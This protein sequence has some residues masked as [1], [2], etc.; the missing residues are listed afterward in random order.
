MIPGMVLGMVHL[1]AT[2][3]ILMLCMRFLLFFVFIIVWIF[4]AAKAY[5]GQWYKLPIIGGF[6][7]STL[8]K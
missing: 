1:S 2:G 6:A 4:A 8:D 5:G 7:W 3:W